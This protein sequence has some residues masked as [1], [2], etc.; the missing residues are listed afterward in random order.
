VTVDL[1]SEEDQLI[2]ELTSHSLALL[3]ELSLT[4]ADV[5]FSD[6]YFNLPA[7]RT[8]QISCL[9]PAGWTLERAR[10]AFCLYSVYDSYSHGAKD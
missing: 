8:I 4:G 1:Y 2:V 5:V 6:N 7:G 10:K 9:L 3:V